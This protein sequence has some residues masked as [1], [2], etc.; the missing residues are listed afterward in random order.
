VQLEQLALVR[1][2]V[3]QRSLMPTLQ[4]WRRV[5]IDVDHPKPPI[6]HIRAQEIA[7]VALRHARSVLARIL[8]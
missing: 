1:F 7:D 4:A 6:A 8:Q 5:W 2:D 3:A